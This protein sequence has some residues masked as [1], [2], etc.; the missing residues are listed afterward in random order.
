[1][2]HTDSTNISVGY[3]PG[4][5]KGKEKKGATILRLDAALKERRRRASFVSKSLHHL[6]EYLIGN[7]P[8]CEPEELESVAHVSAETFAELKLKAL[9]ISKTQEASKHG[10][11][12]KETMELVRLILEL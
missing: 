1:M 7:E 11:Y 12:T 4:P 8:N 2:D 3:A 10:Y 9:S 5:A 6:A